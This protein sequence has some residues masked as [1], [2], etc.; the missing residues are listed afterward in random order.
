MTLPCALVWLA[1]VANA[2]DL[3][4]H[5]RAQFLGSTQRL[6]MH[7]LH[8]PEDGRW[9]E[10]S[11]LDLRGQ[12]RVEEG[13]W[14]VETDLQLVADYGSA[15]RSGSAAAGGDTDSPRAVDLSRSIARDDAHGARLRADRLLVGYRAGDFAISLGRQ[16]LSWGNGQVFTP[17][18]LLSPFAPDAIDRDFKP[19]DDLLL[20]QWQLGEGRDLQLVAVARRD[21]GGDRSAGAGSVGLHWQQPLGSAEAS[22]LLAR[23][24]DDD[25]LGLGLS[26]PAGDAVVRADWVLTRLHDGGYAASLVV[27]ADRSFALGER[28][29]YGFAELY[30]NGVGRSETPR[31]LVGLPPALTARL[32]RGEVFTTSRWYLAVGGSLE[33]HSLVRQQ[34]LAL[35]SLQDG[36]ALLQTSL[37]YEPDDATRIDATLSWS[38]GDGGDEF[39]G[40]RVL[41]A[42]ARPD[43]GNPS[44]TLGGG[45]RA[46]LRYALYWSRSP[47]PVCRRASSCTM[48]LF[49]NDGRFEWPRRWMSWSGARAWSGC[50]PISRRRA[51]RERWCSCGTRHANSCRASMTS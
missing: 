10:D 14:R 2:L 17:M 28:N 31:A 4:W 43:Q 22:L 36:S 19:G 7:D 46:E 25:V 38:G 24:V 1:G 32:G 16:A 5:G 40:I 9:R 29:F 34:L 27:N 23:H 3:E 51:S 39:A 42:A 35:G 26:L 41:P 49:V 45:W 48:G 21:D 12:L 44:A 15:L 20:A 37:R 8:A 33:W 47:G 18:D 6:P 30:R 50:W 13:A 11:R